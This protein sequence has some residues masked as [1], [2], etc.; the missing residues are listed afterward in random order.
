MKY[1]SLPAD[2]KVETLDKYNECNHTYEHSSVIETYGQLT[3]ANVLNSGRVIEGLPE[4]DYGKLETYFNYSRKYDIDFNYTLNPSCMGNFEFSR[5]GMREIKKLL[6]N[7]YSIGIRWLTV[8]SPQL[9]ELVRA[10]GLDFKIKA[11]AICEIMSPD[12]ALFYKNMGVDRIVVDPDITRLFNRLRK[13][14]AVFG[15]EV[16]II[17]NNVCYKNCAYKMFHYNHEAH[18]TAVTDND[19]QTV[20]DYYFNRCAM[21]KAGDLK[22][23]IRMS[24]IRPEDLKYYMDT[25]IYYFKIQGRQNVLKGDPAKALKH[26]MAETYEG[27]LYDLI[28]IFAPYTSFQPYI[29]NKKL[30]NFVKKFFDDPGFCQNTCAACGYCESF[31]KKSMDREKAG[32]LNTQA[33]EFFEKTDRFTGLAKSENS[34]DPE[35]QNNI[36]QQEELNFDFENK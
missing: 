13:I 18:R 30:D 21:Q 8:T 5:Q 16:E 9:I 31:A 26:Y 1:F 7:L 4:V 2:F 20:T 11:S 29:D 32:K 15:S 28:T 6:R 23:V 35:N 24:W 25:G 34:D 27:N 12:K 3:A 17:I 22:N 33:L 36:F 10:S 19:S 14:T